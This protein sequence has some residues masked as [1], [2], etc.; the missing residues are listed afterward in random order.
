[1]TADFCT[2]SDCWCYP[3]YGGA[4][5]RDFVGPTPR[6]IDVGDHVVPAGTL[7]FM[8]RESAP[9]EMWPANFREDEECPGLGVWSCPVCL[10]T[11]TPRE[12][13]EGAC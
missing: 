6:D 2:A 9:R 1:M 12:P 10:G 5:G 7:A 13:Q 3:H 11:K 4:P 8:Q